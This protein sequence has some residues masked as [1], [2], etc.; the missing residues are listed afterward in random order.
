MP[1]PKIEASSPL[2]AFSEPHSI[3]MGVGKNKIIDRLCQLHL[4]SFFSGRAEYILLHRDSTMQQLMFQTTLECGVVRYTDPPLLRAVAHGR[5]LVVD[6]VDKAPEHVVAIFR[7]LAGQ[8]ELT[9]TGRQPRMRSGARGQLTHPS[10]FPPHPTRKPA[11]LSFWGT[12]SAES[13]RRLLTQLA[14]ELSD[15]TE[16]QE[17]TRHAVRPTED[18]PRQAETRTGR[19][20][21]RSAYGQEH[22]R[23]QYR[24]RDTAG[25][26][27]HGG[28]KHLHKKDHNINQ[29]G[30]APRV[31]SNKLKE[32]VP[33]SVRE[34]ACLMARKELE[35]H[36]AELNMTSTSADSY[37]AL[38]TAVQAHIAQL[39][40]LLEHAY[41]FKLPFLS[42]VMCDA[43]TW[44]PRPGDNDNRCDRNEVTTRTPMVTRRPQQQDHNDQGD[45]DEAIMIHDDLGNGDKASTAMSDEVTSTASAMATTTAWFI[46]PH[47]ICHTWDSLSFPSVPLPVWNGTLPASA[48][49]EVCGHVRCITPVPLFPLGRLD[50]KEDDDVKVCR[51]KV[52]DELASSRKIP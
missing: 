15:H 22:I 34:H 11:W 39:H 33:E 20:E 19:S 1:M 42:P 40:D 35:A 9:L 8:G 45:G 43:Q 46:V 14:P 21:R 17:T 49:K 18:R 25:L 29:A 32:D 3:H 10:T 50:N 7:S 26:G 28:F 51:R 13:K 41:Y 30:R 27:G 6:E 4:L 12:I 31:I 23:W 16:S 2:S 37:G 24:G 47:A 48:L 44:L 38:L 5:V 36:L 52:A